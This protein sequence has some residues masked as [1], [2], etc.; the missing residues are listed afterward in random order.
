MKAAEKDPDI[1]GIELCELLGPR[2]S[3][4]RL[5]DVLQEIADIISHG[6]AL[7]IADRLAIAEIVP[8]TGRGGLR[9]RIYVEKRLAEI[10]D[11]MCGSPADHLTTVAVNVLF[12][13]LSTKARD[14]CNRRH[15]RSE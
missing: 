14:V 11:E 2:C 9:R 7:S 15:G 8:S 6:H 13:R 10:F 5:L 4:R 3:D 1:A 12:P